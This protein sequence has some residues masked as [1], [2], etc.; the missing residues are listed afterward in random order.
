[1]PLEKIPWLYQ[2]KKASTWAKFPVEALANNYLMTSSH[3]SVPPEKTSY[4]TDK[5]F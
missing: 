2:N 3:D 4:K 1:M 5:Y